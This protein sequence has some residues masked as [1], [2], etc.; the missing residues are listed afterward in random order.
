[1]P[2]KLRLWRGGGVC[3]ACGGTLW[4]QHQNPSGRTPRLNYLG[5]R[6]CGVGKKSPRFPSDLRLNGLRAAR[7]SAQGRLWSPRGQ[8]SGASV[9]DT[10][11]LVSARSLPL[12]PGGQLLEKTHS[13]WR[14]QH[15]GEMRRKGGTLN[16]LD[17]CFYPTCHSIP[18][19]AP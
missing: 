17:K 12:T 6:L 15:R 1:M 13:G 10:R 8:C 3:Q 5:Q 7:S 19:A 2:S 14:R 9:Q 18:G 4:C 11:Q 16:G